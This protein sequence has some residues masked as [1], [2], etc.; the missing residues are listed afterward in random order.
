VTDPTPTDEQIAELVETLGISV[1]AAAALLAAVE[2]E[3]NPRRG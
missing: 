3:E 2:Y 1:D